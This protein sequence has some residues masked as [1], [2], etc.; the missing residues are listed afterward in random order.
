MYEN[1]DN[2]E[3]L[4]CGDLFQR[5]SNLETLLTLASLLPMLEEMMDIVKKAQQRAM[6]IAEYAHLRKMSCQ[7]LDSLYQNDLNL[8]DE[9][10]NHW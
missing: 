1:Q 8:S 3:N 7:A 2:V 9:R 5:L 4:R 10:F 6:Y